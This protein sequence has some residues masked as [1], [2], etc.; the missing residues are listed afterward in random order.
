MK[1]D[2]NDSISNQF[3]TDF[4]KVLDK[5]L[6]DYQKKNP[7]KVKKLCFVKSSAKNRGRYILDC[8]VCILYAHCIAVKYAL[9][10]VIPFSCG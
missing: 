8:A 6:V 9:C 7:K 4:V 2:K 1:N 3:S 10:K 5:I